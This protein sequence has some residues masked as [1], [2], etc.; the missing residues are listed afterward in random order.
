MRRVS[1][2]E[3]AC[4]SFLFTCLTGLRSS[5]HAPSRRPSQTSRSGHRDAN[6][7][8]SHN[9]AKRRVIG[10]SR[11]FDASRAKPSFAEPVAPLASRSSPRMREIT[12]SH[13]LS[14]RAVSTAL[15]WSSVGWSEG[16]EHRNS[17]QGR[18]PRQTYS[19]SRIG[20]GAT[21]RTR[22]LR[23]LGECVRNVHSGFPEANTRQSR[24]RSE[25]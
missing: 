3:D 17:F 12:Q 1:T 13:I 8:A 6:R 4:A 25:K 10:G 18:S 9:S 19:S 24:R 7:R 5:Q 11:R 2:K 20:F 23:S 21:M 22:P 14:G 16:L 15:W